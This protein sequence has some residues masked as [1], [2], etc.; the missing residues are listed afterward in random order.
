M[1]GHP[2]AGLRRLVVA[3]T[4]ACNLRCAYCFQ[5]LKGSRRLAWPAL[6]RALDLVLSGG[7]RDVRIV[8][9]GGEPL[10][11]FGTL[12]RAVGYVEAHRPPGLRVEYGIVTNGLPLGEEQAAFLVE[13]DFRVDLSFD[14]ARPAQDL[15]GPGTFPTLHALLARLAHEHPAWFAKRLT[16]A[17]TLCRANLPWL[18]DSVEYFLG[19]GIDKIALSPA[20]AR[21]DGWTRADTRR[22]DGQFRRVYGLSVRHYRRAGRIPFL[23]FRKPAPATARPARRGAMCRVGAGDVLALDANGQAYPCLLFADAYRAEHSSLLE[24]PARRLA[25]GGVADPAFLDRLAAL[26]RAARRERLLG[27]RHRKRSSD[28]RCADCEYLDRCTVCPASIAVVSGNRDPDRIP[29]FQCAFARI[30]LKY[31]DRFLAQPGLR[32]LLAYLERN[33]RIAPAEHSAPAS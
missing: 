32:E 2:G 10:L 23:L 4:D 16:V 18:A 8:F 21:D 1:A 7:P 22:L 19:T 30:A 33:G 9:T 5:Q 31:Q 28:R 27:A 14:G 13:H 20:L 24:A 6:R 11:A 12:V 26:P 15:R 3:L 25:L 29:D 17:M